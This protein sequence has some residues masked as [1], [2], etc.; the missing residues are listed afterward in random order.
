MDGLPF[1]CPT[2]RF[3]WCSQGVR[4]VGVTGR[5]LCSSTPGSIGKCCPDC[6]NSSVSKWVRRCEIL[7]EMLRRASTDRRLFKANRGL[8]YQEA[9]SSIKYQRRDSRGS[10]KRKKKLDNRRPHRRI[11]Q[12]KCFSSRSACKSG[13]Y[14]C[15]Q[16]SLS[17]FQDSSEPTFGSTEQYLLELVPCFRYTD[18]YDFSLFFPLAYPD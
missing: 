3:K 13:C 14:F 9:A 8:T 10:L 15:A 18:S 2:R 1:L 6:G 4:K 17:I 16:E 5:Y 7:L 11:K 12:I